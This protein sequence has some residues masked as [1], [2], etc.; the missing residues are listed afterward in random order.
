MAKSLH[1]L[2]PR[3]H[4]AV[5]LRV[6]GEP[7]GAIA[8]A[9]GVEVRTIYVW[10]SDPLF[11]AEIERR[12]REVSDLVSRQLADRLLVGATATKPGP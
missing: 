12:T 1:K 7:P 2:G 4:Q 5:A 8:Q 10:A 9:L 11:K 3:H 6:A